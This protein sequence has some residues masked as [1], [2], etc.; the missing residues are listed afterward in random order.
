MVNERNLNRLLMHLNPQEREIV[1][2]AVFPDSGEDIDIT[3]RDQ[4]FSTVC[5]TLEKAVDDGAIRILKK[6]NS[7]PNIDCP[8]ICAGGDCKLMPRRGMIFTSYGN[9]PYL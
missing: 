4:S 5:L 1:L 8:Y 6:R 9:C 7:P 2:D 3:D